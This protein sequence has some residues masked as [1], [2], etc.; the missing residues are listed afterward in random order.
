MKIFKLS[1]FLVLG[2]VVGLA[3]FTSCKKDNKTAAESPE[4]FKSGLTATDTA[5]VLKMCDAC[6]QTLKEGKIDEALQMIQMVDTN[7]NVSPLDEGSQRKL[8]KT[9]KFFP[10]Y[11][12]RLDKIAFNTSGLNDVKYIIE[13]SEPNPDPNAAPSTI[14]FMFNPV[15][16]DGQWVLTVKQAN[17]EVVSK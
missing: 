1:S 10:V 14:G 12:Y 7:L 6:M 15:K 13:F 16:K 9:F 5:E 4:V 2:L 11:N 8:R 3:V 17:Q